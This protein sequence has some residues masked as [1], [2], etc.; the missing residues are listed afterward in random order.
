[1]R[2]AW[3]SVHPSRRPAHPLVYYLHG[4]QMCSPE[5]IKS[6]RWSWRKQ[7]HPTPVLLPGKIMLALPLQ[8]EDT[9]GKPLPISQ[10]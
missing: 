6:I 1:M 5:F 8:Y 10:E 9:A 2:S 7:W 4:Y 3:S